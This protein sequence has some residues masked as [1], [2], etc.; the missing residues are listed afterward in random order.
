[1]NFSGGL[2]TVAVDGVTITGNGTPASPLV[3]VASG[4]TVHSDGT[5]IQGDGSTGNKLAIIPS[6]FFTMGGVGLTINA[7][8]NKVQLFGFELPTPVTLTHITVNISNA[9][10]SN[11]YDLGIYDA[12][13]NLLAHIG[14]QHLPNIGD[15]TFA[16][17]GSPIALPQGKKLFA[18]TGNAG[19]A[20]FNCN[21]TCYNWLSDGSSVAS[22]GGTLPSTITVPGSGFDRTT[23]LVGLT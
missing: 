18:W 20:Q 4:G 13:G 23:P 6:T 21:Q 16:V 9:D 15:Q 19:G 14:P 5:T 11:L 10:G 3:A 7:T 8:T 1:M 17:V 12:S 22:T 2:N